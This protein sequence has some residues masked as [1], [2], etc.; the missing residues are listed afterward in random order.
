MNSETVYQVAKAL[1]IE[2]Q[3]LLLEK[4]KKDFIPTKTSHKMRRIQFK[5]EDAIDYLLTCVFNKKGINPEIT[6]IKR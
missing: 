1:P 6:T 2:E 5:K 3:M 4:L